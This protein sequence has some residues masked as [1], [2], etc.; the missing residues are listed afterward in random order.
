MCCLYVMSSYLKS[1]RITLVITTEAGG[2]YECLHEILFPSIQQF[3]KH[4]NPN[5]KGQSHG[6]TWSQSPKQ[7][8]SSLWRNEC[9]QNYMTLSTSC[10]HNSIW[11]KVVDPL[12]DWHAENSSQQIAEL[13]S[14]LS[15]LFMVF[16][17]F[18]F[19]C[20]KTA[21]LTSLRLTEKKLS[22]LMEKV[23]YSRCWHIP[24]LHFYQ[25]QY[26]FGAET[27][28]W[29]WVLQNVRLFFLLVV[30]M[31]LI[32]WIFSLWFSLNPLFSC[33]YI[34]S[35]SPSFLFFP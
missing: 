10:W 17:T 16:I 19:I 23:N 27:L 14:G 8:S 13:P 5:S 12:T 30:N 21:S 28:F 31:V 9:L 1:S 2:E 26:I 3:M 29:S 4:F 18:S 11:T 20:C 6:C 15:F 22:Q 24:A 7:V 35:P 25:L 34:F 32:R 33:L